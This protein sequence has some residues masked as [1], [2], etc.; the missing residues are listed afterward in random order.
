MA[1][2]SRDVQD[3][4]LSQPLERYTDATVT[5]PE[6]MRRLLAEVRHQH[7]AVAAGLITPGATGVAVPVRD[8]DGGRVI[9]ALSVVIPHDQANPQSVVAALTMASRGI[10][11]AM[12][13]GSR[14]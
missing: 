10:T 8:T 7:F 14:H 3:E 4:L 6:Q 13:R 9:A 11:R 1:N 12:T 5:D 2:A